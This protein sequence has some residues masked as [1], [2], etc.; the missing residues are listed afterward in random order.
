MTPIPAFGEQDIRLRVDPQSFLRGRAYFQ[1]D[2]IF[3]ARRQDS[4]LKGRCDGSAAKA[5]RLW[6]T[7]EAGALSQAQCSC[8]VGGDGTC[9]HV[10]ALLLTWLH[11][12]EAFLATEDLDTS[13][14]RRSKEDLIALVKQML[15]QRPELEPLLETPLPSGETRREPA[16]PEVYRRQA[17]AVFRRADH[18]WHAAGAVAEE[19]LTIYAIGD[20]FARQGDYASAGAVYSGVCDEVM[21]CHEEFQDEEGELDGVIVACVAGLGTCLAG[22]TRDAATRE[23][24]LQALFAV[25]RFDV[26]YASTGLGDQVPDLLLEHATVAERRTVASWAR[27]ALAEVPSRW[28]VRQVPPPRV[29]RLCAGLGGGGP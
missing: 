9:K 13:L 5:Y 6:A 23:S 4:T 12:P 2:A 17:A 21:E 16:R 29:R 3:D 28:H 18:D 15:R 8:P 11:N 26:D 19:L 22:E 24:I 1:D 10:A 20:G 27:K 25:F 14:H 7:F